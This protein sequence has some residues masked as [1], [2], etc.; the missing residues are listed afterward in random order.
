MMNIISIYIIIMVPGDRKEYRQI[1][2]HVV[3]VTFENVCCYTRNVKSNFSMYSVTRHQDLC[4]F[5]V[6]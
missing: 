2:F 4:A 6:T 5:K 1:V 3:T